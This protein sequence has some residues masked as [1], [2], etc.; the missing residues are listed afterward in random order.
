M[1]S[2]LGQYMTPPY[3]A[4]IAA[5]ELG[6]CDTVIDF[7]VGEGA[8]LNAVKNRSRKPVQLIGLDLDRE[9]VK[10]ASTRIPSALIFNSNGL[11]ARVDQ[12]LYGRTGVIG[13]PPFL[14][15]SKAGLKWIPKAFIGA[16][17]RLGWDRAEVQFLARA[18]VAAR[19]SNGRVVMI[20]PIGF[21]D[22]D[23]YRRLRSIMM[24]QYH[25]IKCIEIVGEKTFR[26][27]EA[28]AVILVIDTA[29]DEPG[30]TSICEMGP[31][32][33][34]PKLI[35]KS[36]LS[37]GSR[38]DAKYHKNILSTPVGRVLLKDLE[39]HIDRGGLSRK[40]AEHLKIPALHT[41]DLNRANGRK[42][43][44]PVNATLHNGVLTAHE[45]DI[46]LP[47]TGSRLRWEPV[48]ICAGESVITDHVFRIR[49]SEAVRDL[50]Y[51]SFCHPQFSSWLKGVTKGVCATVLTK[52][53][54][55]EMPLF[56]A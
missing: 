23:T 2:E 31:E 48:M 43:T 30:E 26:N 21:A 49:A 32:D 19:K 37:P 46:L 28:R 14:A 11:T 16:N 20:M 35:V 34:T 44:V 47:R 56:A 15:K 54:L 12:H 22:G 5:T 6:T 1:K 25:L 41:S 50:V 7:A 45:G 18:L 10:E 24:E 39:V 53:E 42:I 36:R 13:N 4:R 27:T 38:L 8:L 52:S 17:G 51:N 3:L 29:T 33:K 55:L 40:E 9:M